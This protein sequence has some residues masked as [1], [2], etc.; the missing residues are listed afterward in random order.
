MPRESTSAD[1]AG[2]R[3]SERA[4]DQY[5]ADAQKD[6]EFFYDGKRRMLR[7]RHGAFETERLIDGE[8][9]PWDR[10]RL[11]I[12]GWL[13]F[14]VVADDDDDGYGQAE[15]GGGPL[16][17][18]RLARL[19]R[20]YLI[21]D[22]LA[23]PSLATGSVESRPRRG[24]RLALLPPLNGGA[25]RRVLLA[26][27]DSS[28]AAYLDL[29]QERGASEGAG[30]PLEQLRRQAELGDERQRDRGASAET[31]SNY[32]A[33]A[34]GL[35]TTLVLANASLLLGQN[36]LDNPLR[37]LAGAA[38][39]GASFCA[40]MTGLRALQASMITFVRCPPNSVTRLVKRRKAADAAALEREYI[41][42]LLVSQNR[43]SVVADWKI[44]RLQE[45]RRW[46]GGV[47]AG[48]GILTVFVLIQG[49]FLR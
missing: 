14:R 4:V 27:A 15:D 39:L 18:E 36:A 19:A 31:R 40:V 48:V 3:S 25:P 8:W 11:P 9:L 26:A 30:P 47:I 10:G 32:F 21:S 24:L 7:R 33:G 49:A 2:E 23:H 41:A 13:R 12:P 20:K 17:R 37:W 29:L 1:R 38:L 6:Y 16:A 35:T 43:N 44:T 42:A 34:A 22:R 5:A 46:F 45:A 28:R